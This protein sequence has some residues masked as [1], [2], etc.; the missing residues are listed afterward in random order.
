MDAAFVPRLAGWPQSPA[1]QVNSQNWPTQMCLC[2]GH[3]KK[4]VLKIVGLLLLF[5]ILCGAFAF[6]WPRFAIL[7]CAVCFYFVQIFFL[8]FCFGPTPFGK[9][10]RKFFVKCEISRYFSNQTQIHTHM[11]ICAC[12]CICV[13]FFVCLQVGD[14]STR[15][16]DAECPRSCLS[17]CLC[18]L[19]DGYYAH[20]SSSLANPPVRRLSPVPSPVI[21]HR[22]RATLHAHQCQHCSLSSYFTHQIIQKKYIKSIRRLSFARGCSNLFFSSFLFLLVVA[23]VVLVTGLIKIPA[24]YL[25]YLVEFYA[26]LHFDI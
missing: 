21:S 5:A 8:V 25:P 24:G 13:W 11:Y 23:V 3:L 20:L 26:C 1:Q 19:I 2:L 17:T 9:L 12:V 16:L 14:W 22:R 15:L 4:I 10:M 18:R 6:F 7:F